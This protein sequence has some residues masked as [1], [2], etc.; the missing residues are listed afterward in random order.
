ML[1]RSGPG[2][3]CLADISNIFVRRFP[4]KFTASHLVAFEVR[5]LELVL[6]IASR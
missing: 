2:D 6:N 5:A 4:T 1:E 3:L